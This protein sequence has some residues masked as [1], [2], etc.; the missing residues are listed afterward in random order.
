MHGCENHCSLFTG[1][2]GR[3]ELTD[4]QLRERLINPTD[5]RVFHLAVAFARGFSV[6]ELHA[7]TCIDP[8]FLHKLANI[9][10][11]EREL[12]AAALRSF[13][14]VGATAADAQQRPST[15][16]SAPSLATTPWYLHSTTT[17]PSPPLPSKMHRSKAAAAE[18][19][20]AST[21]S[22][23]LLRRAKRYGFS[24]AQ[25]AA[26]SGND[27]FTAETVRRRRR[28]LGI[29]PAVKQIDTLA[30][31]H[32]FSSFISINLHR[33]LLTSRLSQT[34]FHAGVLDHTNAIQ[35]RVP[36]GDELSLPHV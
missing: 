8:F 36:G 19:A 35:G 21:L 12:V 11:I 2:G 13:A 34:S 3:A 7:L 33:L 25:I 27:V 28:A 30:Y 10:A 15:A 22:P 17:Q 4:A 26:L 9:C 31:V 18:R 16:P 23:P 6:D 14:A 5:K 29:L 32:R 20:A 1:D 24:D